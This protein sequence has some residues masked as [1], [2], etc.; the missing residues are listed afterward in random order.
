M[1]QDGELVVREVLLLVV[2]DTTVLGVVVEPELE[3]VVVALLEG[4][5]QVLELVSCESI[6]LLK[7]DTSA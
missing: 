6:Q 2:G 1:P 7:W 4:G 3:V 5:L